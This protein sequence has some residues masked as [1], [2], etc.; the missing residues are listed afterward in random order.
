MSLEGMWLPDRHFEVTVGAVGDPRSGI[1]FV[2]YGS[3]GP[4]DPGLLLR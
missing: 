1:A 4:G 3:V 2:E